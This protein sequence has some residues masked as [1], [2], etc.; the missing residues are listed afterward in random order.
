MWQVKLTKRWH[1]DVDRWY[2]RLWL[3][4]KVSHTLL[5]GLLFRGTAGFS[6]AQTVQI[7]SNSLVLEIVILCMQY[8]EEDVVTV[9]VGLVE[10]VVAGTVAAC[11]CIPGMMLFAASFH[12]QARRLP[13]RSA[14]G[15]P[16]AP[17]AYPRSSGL[18]SPDL[19]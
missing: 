18:A 17:P 12:P 8:I 16:S 6:R 1:G 2:K 13:A 3:T 15:P 9:E 4:C 10:V 14:R 19:A 11:I 7:L 5:A